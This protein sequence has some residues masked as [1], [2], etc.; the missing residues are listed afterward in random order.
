LAGLRIPRRPSPKPIKYPGRGCLDILGRPA[1]K[2]AAQEQARWRAMDFSH[3]FQPWI[4]ALDFSPGFQPWIS[5]LDFSPGFQPWISAMGLC[6]DEIRSTP[7]DHLAPARDQFLTQG[8][9]KDG[10][11][12]SVAAARRFSMFGFEESFERSSRVKRGSAPSPPR[13]KRSAPWLEHWGADS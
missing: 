1:G 12:R 5:A 4:S 10:T 3:G 9:A 2:E 13:L 11:G 7:D 6:R 8:A